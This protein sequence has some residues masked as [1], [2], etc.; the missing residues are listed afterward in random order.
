M[1]RGLLNVS[2]H[3]CSWGSF[4]SVGLPGP[5]L[6]F[7]TM[8]YFVLFGC[9]LPEACSSLMRDIK[10]VDLDGRGYDEEPGG[11]ERGKTVIEIYEKS[12]RNF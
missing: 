5:A 3:A 10:G 6:F 9:Y 2:A 4:P 12:M 11:V 7:L 8:F 1:F